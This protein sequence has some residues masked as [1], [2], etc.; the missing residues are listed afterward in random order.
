[1]SLPLHPMLPLVHLPKVPK[2][3]LCHFP[4]FLGPNV[5]NV[6]IQQFFFVHIHEGR[7]YVTS[8]NGQTLYA[9]SSFQKY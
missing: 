2:K 3:H 1:M 6:N 7:L 8:T 9:L 4:S 5:N